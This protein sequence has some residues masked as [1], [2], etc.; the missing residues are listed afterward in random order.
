VGAAGIAA[1][2]LAGT[3]APALA[4]AVR[5]AVP[6]ARETTGGAKEITGTESV[7]VHLRDAASGEIDVFRGTSQVRLR[8]PEL[9][10]RLM[11]ASRTPA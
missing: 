3:A 10:A 9:A 6:A 2:A 1:T 4:K 8:D 11:R 7:V 5:P